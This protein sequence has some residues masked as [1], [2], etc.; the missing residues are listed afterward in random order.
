MSD[1]AAK[2]NIVER[3]PEAVLSAFSKIKPKS[4]T[5]RPEVVEAHPDKAPDG[6]RDGWIQQD[7]DKAFGRKPKK[8]AGDYRGFDVANVLGDLAAAV[9]GLEKRTRKL[10]S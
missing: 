7:Y 2:E 5:Y 9:H 8:V 1:E 3:D 4:Y 6:D 10:K